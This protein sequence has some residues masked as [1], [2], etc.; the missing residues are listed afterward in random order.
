MVTHA[1]RIARKELKKGDT[2]NATIVIMPTIVWTKKAEKLQKEEV[3]HLY[4]TD[5]I[6]GYINYKKFYLDQFFVIVG[7]EVFL[8][9]RDAV[10]KT[11][12][13]TVE[14]Y[15]GFAADALSYYLKK[16]P[17]IIFQIALFPAYFFVDQ[18][19]FEVL[20]RSIS[21]GDTSIGTTDE[22]LN[23][24]LKDAPYYPYVMP[25]SKYYR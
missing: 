7:D 14:S 24:H 5:N 9:E 21:G 23:F 1:K 13:T 25:C 15:W 6:W 3:I 16:K 2:K 10:S 22:F 12:R 20:Y 8:F 11:Y 19:K 18:D 17:R 4:E